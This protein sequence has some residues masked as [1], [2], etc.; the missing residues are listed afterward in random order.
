MS[1]RTYP[2]GFVMAA[3]LASSVVWL[4]ALLA[5]LPVR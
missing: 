3:A 4:T 2:V 5:Y 1:D